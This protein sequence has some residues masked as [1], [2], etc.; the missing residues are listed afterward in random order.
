MQR[1]LCV[2]LISLFLSAFTLADTPQAKLTRVTKSHHHVTH[3]HAHKATK[4][5]AKRHTHSV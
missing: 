2:L 4:H 5:H 3:H 1:I